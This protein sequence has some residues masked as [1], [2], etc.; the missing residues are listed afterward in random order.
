M[1]NVEERIVQLTMNSKD[2]ERNTKTSIAALEKLD[3]ALRLT[4]SKQSM[5]ELQA[6]VNNVDFSKLSNSVDKINRRF[7]AFGIAGATVIANLTNR[8]T[9]FGIKM[10]NS[11]NPVTQ[12]IKLLNQGINQIKT[13]GWTRATKIDKAQFKIEGLGEDWEKVSQRI[14]YG[15]SE[16][17][18]GFDQAANAAAQLVASGVKMS[19]VWDENNIDDLGVSLRAISG[20]ASMTSA[21]YDLL[22]DIFVDAAAAG[23]VTAD[24]FNRISAQGLNAKATLA[25]AL[26]KTQAEIDEM[27]RKGQISFQEFAKAMDEAYGDQSKKSNKTFEGS[28][29]NMKAALN[30]IGAEFAFPIRKAGTQIFNATRLQLNAFKK[31]LGSTTDDVEDDFVDKFAKVVAKGSDA[32]DRFISSI[33]VD[34]FKAIIDYGSQALD[35]ILGVIDGINTFM[36]TVP[37]LAK[38]EE[39]QVKDT[40]D[41]VKA[42]VDA[43][44]KILELA[45]QVIRGDFGNGEE[46]VQALGKMYKLI[47]NKV[48]EIYGDPKRYELEADETAEA[49]F[50]VGEGAEQAAKNVIKLHE[51]QED[52]TVV[53]D[54]GVWGS[55]KNVSNTE[56]ATTAIEGFKAALEVLGRT[57]ASIG[58][59]AKD[60][61]IDFGKSIGQAFLDAGYSIGNWIINFRTWLDESGAYEKISNKISEV[62][63]WIVDKLK[64]IGGLGKKAF[65]LIGNAVGK[66]WTAIGQLRERIGEFFTS[67]KNT[68]GY[69]RL[70]DTFTK[71]RDKVLEAKETIVTAISD[72]ITRFMGT[73]IKLPEFDADAFASSVSDKVTWVLDHLES[74]K[75]TITTFFVGTGEEGNGGL[76]GFIQDALGSQTFQDAVN[77]A[78]TSLSTLHQNILNFIHSLT[79]E[80][81]PTRSVDSSIE[82]LEEEKTIGEYLSPHLQNVID[83]LTGF[84]DNLVEVGQMIADAIPG[85]L[86]SIVEAFTGSSSSV[87]DA[88]Q[89][90]F[91]TI[92]EK[93]QTF[94]N[95]I[96]DAVSSL[97]DYLPDSLSDVIDVIHN[98]VDTVKD[99]AKDIAIIGI[100]KGIWNFSG[101]LGGVSKITKNGSKVVKAVAKFVD[102]AAKLPD[103][104]G[105]F[106]DA[107]GKSLK[108]LAKSE[109]RLR[110]AKAL[111]LV[112]ASLAILVGVIY[113]IAQLKPSELYRGL[114][115]I[116]ILAIILGALFA[117]LGYFF[118]HK[119]ATNIDKAPTQLSDAL[120]ACKAIFKDF[121]KN[122]S[123]A[124]LI[125][126]IGITIGLIAGVIVTLG[127]MDWNAALKGVGFLAL[128]L[129]GLLGSMYI[130]GKIGGD[131]KSKITASMAITMLFLA[132]AVRCLAGT[133][134]KLGRMD[135]KVLLKGGM[136]V[137]V[138]M[139]VLSKAVKDMNNVSATS[140]K[141]SGIGTVL[142]IVAM[143]IALAT[144]GKQI[145]KLGSM[146]SKKLLKGG[147]AVTA[148]VL[149]I[150][151][152]V[153]SLGKVQGAQVTGLYSL[154][155]LISVL[156]GSL[157]LLGSM[158][159]SVLLRGTLALAGITAMIAVLTHVTGKINLKKN[160]YMPILSMVAVLG[161][162]AFAIKTISKIDP[163]S[164]NVSTKSIRKVLRSL[165]L[166]SFTSGRFNKG[167]KWKSI[168]AGYL[169]LSFVLTSIAIVFQAL[170]GMDP[171]KMLTISQAVSAMIVSLSAVTA[172]IAL[173]GGDS[174]G[175]VGTVKSVLAFDIV[176]ANIVAIEALAAAVND[177]FPDLASFLK[178]GAPLLQEIGR[179]IGSLI[180]G[181]LSGALFEPIANNFSGFDEGFTNFSTAILNLIDAV[182]GDEGI[183]SAISSLEGLEGLIG[184]LSRIG[185]ES[186]FANVV[187]GMANPQGTADFVNDLAELAQPLYKLALAFERITVDGEIV[188]VDPNELKEKMIVIQAIVSALNAVTWGTALTSLGISFADNGLAG[189]IGLANGNT[190]FLAQLNKNSAL[191]KI[192]A[193]VEELT[194]LAPDLYDLGFAFSQIKTKTDTNGNAYTIA[195]EDIEPKVKAIGAIVSAIGN[196]SWSAAFTTWGIDTANNDLFGLIGLSQNNTFLSS[197]NQ[198]GDL[199]AVGKIKT[200][201]TKLQTLA[202]PL[203]ELAYAFS[204]I[205]TKTDANG[206][207]YTIASEDIEPKVKAIGAIVSAIGNVSW[208]AAFTTWGIDTA[209]GSITGLIGLSQNNTFLSSLNQLSDQSA[210]G[211]IKT[212][213]TKL[214]TL[215]NPLY[216]L[217]YAFSQIKTKTDA[218]GNAYTIASED[219]EPKVKAIGAIVSAI[220]NVSWSAA[221][222]TWGIDTANG[223]I[224]GL[225]G[226]S[227]NNTFLSSLN[228]LSDQSAVGKIKTFVTKLQTLANPLYELAY[229]FSQIKT[230]TDANGNAYTIASEDI[231]PKVKAI[232]AI[233]SAIGEA[234]WMSTFAS[235]GIDAGNEGA[236]GLSTTGGGLIG[237][238]S[239]ASKLPFTSGSIGKTVEQAPSSVEKIRTFIENLQD[240]AQPL[241]DLAG[242]FESVT[243]TGDGVIDTAKLS[244]KVTAI[245]SMVVAIGDASWASVLS[246]WGISTANGGIF[247]GLFSFFGGP[248][249]IQNGGN[250]MSSVQ[251]VLG[252]DAVGTMITFV[253]SLERLAQPLYNLCDAFDSLGAEVGENTPDIDATTL[254]SKIA[255]IKTM[256]TAIGDASWASVLSTWSISI[257]NG[258]IL[259]GLFSFFG[260]S[261]STGS[262]LT[263]LLGTVND[264]GIGQI[265]KF[266]NRLSALAPSLGSLANA[267]SSMKVDEG[268]TLDA[269]DVASKVLAIRAMVEA[270]GDTAWIS[271][272]GKWKI[273]VA[274][275]GVVS[276][277]FN[278]IGIGGGSNS[279]LLDEYDSIIQQDAVG[280]ITR[281][282]GQVE[283]LATPLSNLISAFGPI[284]DTS[285]DA[286]KVVLDAEDPFANVKSVIR[287]LGDLSTLIDEAYKEGYLEKSV[288]GLFER[289]SEVIGD[290][291]KF[292]DTL[293]SIGRSIMQAMVKGMV[294]NKEDAQAIINALFSDSVD[295]EASSSGKDTGDVWSLGLEEAIA[296]CGPEIQSIFTS[297][298]G[299]LVSLTDTI[300]N[301]SDK[302]TDAVGAIID[303]MKLKMSSYRWTLTETMASIL[304][305]VVRIARTFNSDFVNVGKYLIDGLITGLKDPDKSTALSQTVRQIGE[306]MVRNMK[307]STQVNSPSKATMEIGRFLMEGLRI[308][309]VDNVT[310]VDRAATLS[311]ASIVRTMSDSVTTE[312]DNTKQQLFNS[313]V[314]L[315]SLVNMA[316]NE[317]VD[318]Q[319]TITPVMDLSM[320]QNGVNGINGM[321]GRG[322]SFGANSLAYARNMFPGTTAYNAQTAAQMGTQSAIQG[323]REDI[324]YL[325]ETIGNMQMVLDSGTLVGSISGGMDKQLG[326][327]QRMKERWA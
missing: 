180:G 45:N 323:I 4:G 143:M 30:R 24:T 81:V 321:L 58:T 147:I 170:S 62:T 46:R 259:G 20:V 60:H 297:D 99:F 38:K 279:W 298:E 6:S 83:T 240:L 326:G 210:V 37:W 49:L 230:K 113:A 288:Q 79:G 32:I 126:S 151:S 322:Y 152:I 208:S 164:L 68:E 35:T 98:V 285:E 91:E 235:W 140:K 101:I 198:L 47:Q 270:L 110:N 158:K 317:A 176:L 156:V 93:I 192:K 265:I 311:A 194:A 26:D 184:V 145:D 166:L 129:G 160:S 284:I 167:A 221:F 86:R 132:F 228:Q 183:D 48:N 76:F 15:V 25:K 111:L 207:A 225:I 175:V 300:T 308:G 90:P 157:M 303:A 2:F 245:K 71:V 205:K 41:A 18:Y 213:V 278:A 266:A 128:I 130:L 281:F 315:Y 108:T 117:V 162:I 256:V 169:G 199:S 189:L 171:S 73:E 87:I 263:D 255:A 287:D 72:A 262:V 216:E 206:N 19:D 273:G 12:S 67:F 7:S 238:L 253:K 178:K 33:P 118:G 124:A 274:N 226:L 50:G 243:I 271:A 44:A 115:T 144:L 313:L 61:I 96:S 302:F 324:R 319:P 53:K 248:S 155:L 275:D 17:A 141:G 88:V 121:L 244:S 56:K 268:V 280:E 209:N 150:K 292:S 40:T 165:S 161:A 66:A 104:I 65:G 276:G 136:V 168:A 54:M 203:Y 137:T 201:V 193:F 122:I 186:F 249:N 241:Y 131:D 80:T 212:F 325:G 159:P 92:K 202:N 105:N 295:S 187:G 224:T 182:G 306:G 116:G 11:I 16:T 223:S 8:A 267:F 154:S 257:A 146:D 42:G 304:N 163:K 218:N 3:E 261:N 299:I 142:T 220:G 84:K 57:A 107:V 102:K 34:S 153:K 125:T 123:K 85:M 283:Q 127:S 138:L 320:I 179:T 39:E 28:F 14:D 31:L 78:N 196:V 211:K 246:T 63:G 227:Q 172:S 64:V 314:G 190:N 22:A 119:E 318:T 100:F 310:P 191:N 222:T 36:D 1:S 173:L 291:D 69:T 294:A 252:T 21:N 106:I 312:A 109:A 217:A 9:D 13:G 214:Q 177:K 251:R 52:L 289:L 264:D 200:F 309:I 260:G 219:I 327:M 112:S 74:I 89:S 247:G 43:E 5:K 120:E 272:L 59:G 77:W 70:S 296:Q 233:I 286:E 195:S 282:A 134:Q 95:G 27:S 316:I 236:L 10:L 174:L 135:T 215:A 149:L 277:I 231:E 114:A 82:L 75:N 269:D 29:D 197:L 97:A 307:E 237:L 23:K 254:E 250:L 242:A 94:I 148:L 305:S 258:G 293:G 239:N 188:S 301:S 103:K 234:S 232:G 139:L 229:A 51:A 55:F 185:L 181:F 290:E 133:I 204:Q